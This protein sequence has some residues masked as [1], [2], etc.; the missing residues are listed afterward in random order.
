MYIDPLLWF[1]SLNNYYCS[2]P[3]ISVLTERSPLKRNKLWAEHN[4]IEVPS[5]TWRAM[6]ITHCLCNTM[7]LNLQLTEWQSVYFWW[8]D[9]LI[10][11]LIVRANKCQDLTKLHGSMLSLYQTELI[12]APLPIDPWKYH[13]FS[14][15]QIPH[16]GTHTVLYILPLRIFQKIHID[17]QETLGNYIQL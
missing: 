3:W 17:R 13:Q 10:L 2:F 8:W 6:N 7:Y 15:C 4:I 12:N 1:K 5:M 11:L 9:H 14:W 16:C